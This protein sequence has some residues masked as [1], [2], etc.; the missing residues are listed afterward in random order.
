[1]VK[2]NGARFYLSSFSGT[3]NAH[4]NAAMAIQLYVLIMSQ[5]DVSKELF[6]MAEKLKTQL[7]HLDRTTE[8]EHALAESKR[9]RRGSDVVGGT[10]APV[11]SVDAGSVGAV[12]GVE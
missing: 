8:L 1:M 11:S 10:D 4:F 6:A 9:I 7:F 12:A 5:D 2:N 3:I